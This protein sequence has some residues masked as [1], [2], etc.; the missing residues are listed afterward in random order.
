MTFEVELNGRTRSVSIERA[1]GHDRFRVTV[2]GVATLVDVQ[3]TGEFRL[4]LLFPDGA[5]SGA[6]VAIAPGAA[7]G[8][9]LAYVRGRSAAVVVN[10]RRSGRAAE[11]GGGAQ[12]E[13][14]IA[15][16]MPGRVVR[17]LV[18]PGDEVQVRQPVVVVEAMKMENE[19]RS[20]KTGRV[21][22]VAVAAGASVEAGRVLMVIE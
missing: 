13:Q 14:K 4:S 17:L 2:D 10:G 19:L 22:D 18:A 9:M 3:R 20:P 8:E 12:G 5:H 1:G 11:S 6:H 16:P 21:K 7:A 15:A